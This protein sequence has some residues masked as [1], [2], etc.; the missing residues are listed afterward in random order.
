MPFSVSFRLCLLASLLPFVALPGLAHAED[1]IPTGGVQADSD[2]AV[3]EVTVTATRVSTLLPDV[4]A[5]VTVITAAEMETRGYTTLTQALSAVPGLGVVQTGGPGGQASVFIR[6]TNSEDVLVLLDGVPVNDP[7]G[8]NGAFNFGNYTLSDIE[9][10][11]VVRG[12]MSGLY[13]SNAIGGVINIITLRGSGKPTLS[14]TAAGGYPAQGQGSATIS[15]SSGKF[16]Y[17]LSG[18][19]DQQAGFDYTAQRLSVY[20]PA[21]QD[22][23]RSKLGSLNLGYTPIDGTRVS[24]VVRAQQTDN[25]FPDLGD[26]VFDDPNSVDTNE[27]YFYKLGVVSN[28][29]SGLLTTELFAAHMENNLHYSN[30]L[31]TADPNQAFNDDHYYGYRDDVQWNNT[32]HVPDAGPTQ[33]SSVLFGMEYLNDRAKENVNDSYFGSPYIAT[34]DHSQHDVAGHLGAQ[35]TVL[36]QLTLTGAL[37]DDSYSSFGNAF[38]GRFGGVLAV[39]AADLH[40]KAS[41]GTGF[42][43]PS[44]FDL[45]GVDSYG[46]QGNPNLKPERSQGYD[47]GAQFDIPAFGQE[48]FASLSATYFHNN[49]HDLIQFTENADFTQSTEENIDQAKISGVETEAVLTPANWLSADLTYT[50]TYARDVTSETPLLRRPE[51]AGGAT[52]TLTPTPRITIVPQVQYIGQFSDFLY[53]NNGFALSNGLSNPGTLVNLTVNYALAARYK[54]FANAYNLLDSSFEPINGLQI[55]GASFIIGIRADIGL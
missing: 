51:N 17:A 27:N 9:R 1:N 37:R 21:N 19:I 22:P 47:A 15:G 18:A 7:S 52:I 6:G 20:N 8:P 13:G 54:L 30:L 45:Y 10:I 49:I 5:G 25:A 55:P 33:F 29:F 44:L 43:A 48:D 16:D 39:P 3:P 36:D 2:A 38:T 14:V 53:D 40:L 26:P 23:Y 41:Y 12:P 11:E 31:D 42:L 50:Y 46:Y 35:T 34:V 24:L 4:P 32:V 28:L